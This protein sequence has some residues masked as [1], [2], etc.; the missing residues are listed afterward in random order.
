MLG[1]HDD[2]HLLPAGADARRARGRR[3]RG[4]SSWPR[5]S[6]TAWLAPESILGRCRRDALA[7]HGRISTN[8]MS[9]EHN[10]KVDL[11]TVPAS[12]LV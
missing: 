6:G 9:A 12:V 11:G 8:G 2:L 10:A 1:A 7:L 4:S 5:A 3:R